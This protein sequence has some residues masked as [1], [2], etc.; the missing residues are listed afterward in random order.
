MELQTIDF[1]PSI[2]QFLINHG[3]YVGLLPFAR[4]KSRFLLA[5]LKSNSYNSSPLPKAERLG[6]GLLNKVFFILQPHPQPLRLCKQRGGEHK[7]IPLFKN[8]QQ[9][10]R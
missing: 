7:E 5:D 1:V 3:C 8:R 9:K 2:Y 6:V 10:R 4:H